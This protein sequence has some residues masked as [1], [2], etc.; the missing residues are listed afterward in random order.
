MASPRSLRPHRSAP[1]PASV[2]A[3]FGLMCAT[4]VVLAH[5]ASAAVATTDL[6]GAQTASDLANALAS[7]GIAVDADSVTYT[8]DLSAAGTFS[9]GSG[10]IGLDGGVILSSGA[11]ANVIGPNDSPGATS[12]FGGP[13]D[14]DLTALA[15]AA[16][17]DAAVLQFDFVPT[18]SQVQFS[19]VFSSEE[20]N[21]FVG[22][23]FNDAF[24]FFVNETNCAVVGDAAVPVAVDTI[25]GG[26]N[27]SLFINNDASVVTQLDTEMDGLTVV[28]TCDAP[29]T[30]DVT[31]HM[32]LAIADSGDSSLDSAVFLGANSFVA[33]HTLSVTTAGD[34]SGTVTSVPAGID[35]GADCSEAYEEGTTVTLSATPDESS[36]FDGWSGD[37]TGTGTCE[38]AMG[39]TR[40]VTATFSTT[41]SCGEGT[42][43]DSGTVPPGGTLTTVQ[44]TQGNPVS[45]ADPFALELQNVSG[46]TVTGTIVEEAC[47]GTQDGD[48][49]CSTPRIGGSAGNFQ[50]TVDGETM[51]ATAD[52]RGP[53]PVTIGK[54]FFDKSVV[55]GTGSAR[56]FYQ[57]A[58]GGPVLK[59][60]K[61]NDGRRTECFTLKKLKSGDQIVT[62]PFKDDPR[63][64]RG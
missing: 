41:S 19:Y 12:A 4:V 15:G 48:A 62:V 18:T 33:V 47:D 50:F 37:C 59:L 31:N 32:K 22:G 21:E 53:R 1:R 54:L 8:G 26:S 43:C 24:G 45:P 16:T 44:G 27:S 29:V 20:Y 58:F 57:K 25:N 35:C 63:V 30:P 49:L 40:N 9:G 14:V 46:G 23:G 38:V 42:D 3:V 34:G 10:I 7:G 52:G 36:V 17:A 56:I 2:V 61:C 39:G 28:L 55:R 5:P 60:R 13:G 51:E 64:T 6:T 11:I